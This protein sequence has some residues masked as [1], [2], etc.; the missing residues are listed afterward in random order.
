MTPNVCIV[1]LGG[2]VGDIESAPFIEA[3]RQLQLKLG[4]ENCVFG[5][6]S[7]VPNMSGEQKTKP[8]QHSVQVLRSLGL[9]PDFLFCRSSSPL[10]PGTIEKLS[11]FSQVKKERVISVHDV[12]NIFHVPMLL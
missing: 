3:L 1:E 10:E 4:R 6:V 2:T 11:M 8:T 12:P 7:L 9:F 5:H